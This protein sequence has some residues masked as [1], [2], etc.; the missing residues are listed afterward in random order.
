MQVQAMTNCR[1]YISN[2]GAHS[3]DD[4]FSSLILQIE[5]QSSAFSSVS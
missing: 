1:L 3:D 5:D 4:S 2:P